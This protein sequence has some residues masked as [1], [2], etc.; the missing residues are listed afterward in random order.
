MVY[1]IDLRTRN[2]AAQVTGVGIDPYGVA[3]VEDAEYPV[4]D[5]FLIVTSKKCPTPSSARS[6]QFISRPVRLRFIKVYVLSLTASS[7]AKR[8]TSPE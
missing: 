6:V 7:T 1:V 8:G 2:V 3:V 5:L 4:G